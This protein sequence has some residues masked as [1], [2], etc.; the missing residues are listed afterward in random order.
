VL[1]YWNYYGRSILTDGTI[2]NNR[3]DIIILD[4]TIKEAYLR[5]AAIAN[6]H[7]IHIS[8]TEKIH[9]CEIRACKNMANEIGLYNTISTK[10][11]NC[12]TRRDCIHFITFL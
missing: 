1:E 7:N 2:H 5:D 4:S 9:K 3:P 6:S 12:P 8:I 10:F 11:N